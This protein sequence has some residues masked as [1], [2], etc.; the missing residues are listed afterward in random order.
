[1]AGN[2][3]IQSTAI[4]KLSDVLRLPWPTE[5]LTQMKA[6]DEELVHRRQLERL[7][8]ADAVNRILESGKLPTEGVKGV[9]TVMFVDIRN[10]AEL[11]ACMSPEEIIDFLNT[12]LGAAAREILANGGSVNKFIGDGILAV[13]GIVDE[14][15]HGVA[16][17]LS[18]ARAIHASFA[19]TSE[20][21]DRGP[22]RAVVVVNTGPAVIGVVGLAERS[23][24][25]VLGS[26]VNVASRLE[27]EAKELGLGTAITGASV[28][29]LHEP[30][31]DLELV[32][33]RRLRGIVDAVQVWTI[34]A[35]PA[36][37]GSH[38]HSASRL[39]SN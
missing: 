7:L 1:M 33:T 6:I 14:S 18:A 32:G 13:F 27:A 38:R 36:V 17:A 9:L 4:R 23:D 8:P 39:S 26:T 2:P 21:L 31:P 11:E 28:G 25:A 19:V 35:K 22:V 16:N 5:A 29:Y 12:Y 30:R 3:S 15:D 34:A 24:Y 37:Q 20:A 10:S